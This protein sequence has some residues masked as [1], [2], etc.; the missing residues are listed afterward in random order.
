MRRPF[1]VTGF[2]LHS[3]ASY[4]QCGPC[5]WGDTCTVDPPFPTVCPAIPPTA[6]VGVPY[7]LDV[8][9]WVPPSFPEPTTQ[10]NVILDEVGL[11]AIEN[12]PVGLNYEA[13]SP[14]LLYHPQENPFGCVRVCGV[15][16]IAGPDTIRIHV[17]ATGTVG[18]IPTS[19]PY[20]LSLPIM[21]QPWPT[22]SLAGFAST[23]D[24]SCAPAQV[25]FT[26]DTSIA[27]GV[28]NVFEWDFGNG[29]VFSGQ[30]PPLQT[31]TEG[32]DYEVSFTRSYTA[33]VLVSLSLSGVNGAWCG[34]LDEP[35][36]PLVGC[37]GQPDLYFTITDNRLG[38]ERSTTLNNTQSG[39]WTNQ[40]VVLGFP[41]FELRV[42]DSDGLSDDDLLGT[43]GFDGT[44]GAHPFSSGGTYGEL[45]V[46]VQSLLD[47]SVTN[48]IHVLPAP[49]VALSLDL[50]AG[51]LCVENDSLAAYSWSLDG[52][53]IPNETAACV[54][55]QNGL[56]TVFV[57][58]GLGC[59]ASASFLVAGVGVQD[60]ASSWESLS[61]Q[62]LPGFSLLMKHPRVHGPC[63]MSV[64][65]PGGRLVLSERLSLSP[66]GQTLVPIPS[67]SPGAYSVV[68]LAGAELLAAR[69]VVTP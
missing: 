23:P 47:L 19:R 68:I 1:I 4:G 16:V 41:P 67:L 12:V 45:V 57:T 39:S 15:P 66:A 69:L 37:L 13:S 54:P 2:L 3:L 9:F 48:S 35:N 25:L 58:D 7:G 22:D 53:P 8:T 34:D 44:A 55:A 51:L 32:G 52:D 21:V 27:Q 31:F 10:L 56:W 65:E 43:F 11:D 20:V 29:S 59:S 40:S 24:S 61:I 46:E 49:E 14:D 38:Q 5:S 64:F 36:L 60:I 28:T 33:P 62:L 50:F 42:Y 63:R 30:L 6:F 18:G 17:T 26:A